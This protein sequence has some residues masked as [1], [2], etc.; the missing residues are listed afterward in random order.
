MQ[1]QYSL[2]N[3][4][5]LPRDAQKAILELIEDPSIENE[6]LNIHFD[7]HPSLFFQD[8]KSRRARRFWKNRRL[9]E[10]DESPHLY[11]SR[12]EALGVDLVANKDLVNMAKPKKTPTRKQ[13]L[14]KGKQVKNNYD[15]DDSLVEPYREESDD[16]KYSTKESAL[17]VGSFS[18][19]L[20]F[21]IR[22]R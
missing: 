18:Q 15:D 10:I 17:F 5:S 8:E 14:R 6:H 9:K 22:R 21:F 7:R 20:L 11:V 2:D 13:P 3:K 19:L 16:C 1:R 4:Q 12:C